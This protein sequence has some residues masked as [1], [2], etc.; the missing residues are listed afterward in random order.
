MFCLEFFL[1]AVISANFRFFGKFYRS[2]ELLIEP[3]R[4]R[5]SISEFSLIILVGKSDF[6]VTLLVSRFCNSFLI[7]FTDAFLNGSLFSKCIF[8][9]A[10]MLGWFWYLRMDEEIGSSSLQWWFTEFSGIDLSPLRDYFEIFI[11]DIRYFI[12][13]RNNA[14][15]F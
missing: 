12:V 5:T 4:K 9:M 6:W 11:E 14:I 13:I 15:I 2:I 1:Y 10:V 8:L 3:R 7:S